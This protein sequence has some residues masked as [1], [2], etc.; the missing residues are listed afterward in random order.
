LKKLNYIFP[1]YHLQR[2]LTRIQ[3]NIQ[4]KCSPQF[5]FPSFGFSNRDRISL[6]DFDLLL[7]AFDRAASRIMLERDEI[8]SVVLKP[9]IANVFGAYATSVFYSSYTQCVRFF[10]LDKNLFKECTS[11]LQKRRKRQQGSKPPGNRHFAIN[12]SVHKCFLVWKC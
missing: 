8:D 2:H 12:L 11:I 4:S 7:R 10:K 3:R 6:F 9:V 5:F 1:N